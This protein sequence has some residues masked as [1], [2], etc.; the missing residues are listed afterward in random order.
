MFAYEPENPDELRL[1]EG[2]IVTVLNKDIAESEGWWEG[3]VN[4]KVGMFPDN[5]VE[6]LPAEEED[7]SMKDKVRNRCKH[8]GLVVK[9]CDQRVHSEFQGALHLAKVSG[10]EGLNVNGMHRSNEGVHE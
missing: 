1:V 4:G 2:D 3:E 6:L 5:F 7:A 9:T 8:D 10:S